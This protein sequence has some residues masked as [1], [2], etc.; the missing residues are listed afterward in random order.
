[1]SDN[2]QSPSHALVHFRQQLSHTLQK[3]E[4]LALT[5]WQSRNLLGHS[6]QKDGNFLENTE[7]VRLKLR[8]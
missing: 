1:M 8:Q 6:L 3:S 4:G 2:N 7:K 5:L